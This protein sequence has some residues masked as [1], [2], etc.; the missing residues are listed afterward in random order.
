MTVENEYFRQRFSSFFYDR[1]ATVTSI[2]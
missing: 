1:F 2:H